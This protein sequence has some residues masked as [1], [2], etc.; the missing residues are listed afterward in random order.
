[1]RWEVWQITPSHHHLFFY[2]LL[3]PKN[4][5]FITH[6]TSGVCMEAMIMIGSYPSANEEDLYCITQ[7]TGR[8]RT[9]KVIYKQ[10]VISTLKMVS[11]RS[12]LEI[13]EP[14]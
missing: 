9:M 3:L 14:V 7:R 10:F 2:F 1:M 4:V 13:D 12:K 5:L 6:Y 11:L 8:R